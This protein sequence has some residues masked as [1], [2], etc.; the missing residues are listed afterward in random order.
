MSDVYFKLPKPL[1]EEVKTI[2][3]LGFYKSESEFVKDAIKTFLSA[4]PDIR[5]SLAVELYKEGVISL[6]RVSELTGL[7]CDEAKRLLAER[8]VEIGSADLPEVKKGAKKL[9]QIVK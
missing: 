8:G 6:G 2:P 5:I 7:G 4:R 3:K 1:A 9:L